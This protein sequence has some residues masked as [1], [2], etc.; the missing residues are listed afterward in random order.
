MI[1]LSCAGHRSRLYHLRMKVPTPLQQVDRTYVQFAGGRYSYFAGCDY[2]RLASH[3]RVLRAAG[4]ARDRHGLNVAAS[5]KS[6][7]T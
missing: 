1:V 6:P 2:Y 3:P 7:W 5:P 4:V